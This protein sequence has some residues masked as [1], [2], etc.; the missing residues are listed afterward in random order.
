MFGLMA[1][2]ACAGRPAS[3]AHVTVKGGGADV[4]SAFRPTNADV[5]SVGPHPL[6]ISAMLAR[7]FVTAQTK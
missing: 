1:A 3:P 2:I 4:L 7:V 5:G 6:G